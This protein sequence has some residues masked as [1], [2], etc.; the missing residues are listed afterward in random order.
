MVHA[1]RIIGNNIKSLKY[2]VERGGNPYCCEAEDN[3]LKS[4]IYNENN[5]ASIEH[6]VCSCTPYG[7]KKG[8]KRVGKTKKEWRSGRLRVRGKQGPLTDNAN[9]TQNT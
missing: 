9:S 2:V 7:Y 5:F 8:A 1:A 4:A 3:Q 6:S